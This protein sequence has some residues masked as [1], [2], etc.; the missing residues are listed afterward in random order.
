[1]GSLVVLAAA[2]LV[3]SD[4]DGV[5]DD[6]TFTA[7]HD[8]LEPGARIIYTITIDLDQEPAPHSVRVLVTLDPRTSLVPVP[9]PVV[10]A[11]AAEIEVAQDAPPPPTVL[12]ADWHIAEDGVEATV[13]APPNGAKLTL[14]AEVN[15]DPTGKDIVAKV[16][17]PDRDNKHDDDRKTVTIPVV[18][19]GLA[20]AVTAAPGPL[21][22]LKPGD[23]LT[24]THTL[25]NAAA[26]E[27]KTTLTNVVPAGTTFVAL[28]SDS[29]WTCPDG[30]PAGT[31][32]TRPVTIPASALGTAPLALLVP[33]VVQIDASHP[34]ETPIVN[35]ASTSRLGAA[36]FD[37]RTDIQADG[38][39]VV[40]WEATQSG[41]F[42]ALET[43]IDFSANNIGTATAGT[44]FTASVTVDLSGGIPT[45][46]VG[47]DTG[48]AP[49]ALEAAAL[50]GTFRAPAG[51]APSSIVAPASTPIAF[52]PP[53]T[54]VYSGTFT[55]STTGA[56]ELVYEFALDWG[57]QLVLPAP[58]QPVT[59]ESGTYR[60]TVAIAGDCQP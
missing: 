37:V 1:M 4:C 14:I 33:F 44:P 38:S 2:L 49:L 12:D 19:L 3:A 31:A 43:S 35:E 6:V 26:K 42:A 46:D 24:Y 58:F 11:E 52:D 48:I 30:A 13:L 5:K 60:G 27:A 54:T 53:S 8:S 34:P 15:A 59:I 41:T 56:F 16:E 36:V 9:A 57:I 23:T 40:T 28:G 22:E 45:V 17:L 29:L 18:D 10:N 51:V 39:A 21:S 20:S 47:S 55:C 32:C 25:T 7:S 50:T